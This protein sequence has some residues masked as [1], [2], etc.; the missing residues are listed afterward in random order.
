MSW[1][2]CAGDPGRWEAGCLGEHLKIT[3]GAHIALICSDVL[4]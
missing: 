4:F 1:S 2:R 3:V